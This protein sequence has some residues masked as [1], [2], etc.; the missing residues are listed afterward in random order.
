[1]VNTFLVYLRFQLLRGMLTREQFA[2]ECEVVR[3]HL[4]TLPD[5]HWREFLAAW[6]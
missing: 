4:A 5:E 3:T 6:R 1:M 2:A